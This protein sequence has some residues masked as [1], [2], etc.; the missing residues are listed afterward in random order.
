VRP[1]RPA[2]RPLARVLTTPRSYWQM[3]FDASPRS[4]LELRTMLRRDP[5]VVRFTFLKLAHRLDQL[6]DAGPQTITTHDPSNKYA[7]PE[8]SPHNIFSS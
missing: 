6:A 8:L 4:M 5:R 1:R 3:D 7:V 2:T